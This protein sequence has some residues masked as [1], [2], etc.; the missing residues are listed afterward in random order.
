MQAPCVSDD[1]GEHRC[2]R[3]SLCLQPQRTGGNGVMLWGPDRICPA[4]LKG[5]LK[6]TDNEK[7]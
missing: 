5:S 1:P 7:T 4:S 6:V 3:P 2:A